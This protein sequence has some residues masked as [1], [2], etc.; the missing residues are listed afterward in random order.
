MGLTLTSDPLNPRKD[1]LKN[2]LKD[3]LKDPLEDPLKNPPHIKES[4]GLSR[5]NMRLDIGLTLSS[6]R[7]PKL[8]LLRDPRKDPSKDPHI[9]ESHGLN[10][11]K[12]RLN[13]GLTLTCGH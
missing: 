7:I 13:H 10:W 9:K 4:R 8:S 12:M 2:P 3:P 11:I 1:P 6:H 5:I